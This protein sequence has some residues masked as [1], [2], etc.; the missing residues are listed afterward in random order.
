MYL[1]YLCEYITRVYEVNIVIYL[2]SLRDEMQL[3][4]VTIINEGNM[5]WVKTVINTTTLDRAFPFRD[6]ND[7]V[8]AVRMFDLLLRQENLNLSNISRLNVFCIDFIEDCLSALKD[9]RNLIGSIIVIIHI[10]I[11]NGIDLKKLIELYREVNFNRLMIYYES[12]IELYNFLHNLRKIST[13]IPTS[14]IARFDNIASD[15]DF[16]ITINNNIRDMNMGFILKKSEEIIN[17]PGKIRPQ[18]ICKKNWLLNDIISAKCTQFSIFSKPIFILVPNSGLSV[19]GLFR[20]G[21][22]LIN[23]NQNT[24]IDV[25]ELKKI[26]IDVNPVNRIKQNISLFIGIRVN[27]D[28]IISEEDLEILRLIKECGCLKKVAEIIGSSYTTVRKRLL[29]LEKGLGAKV[30]ISKRGGSDKGSTD[31]LPLGEELL[32]TFKPLIEE[33]KKLLMS[34][35]AIRLIDLRN[36]LCKYELIE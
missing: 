22:Q 5:D 1:S 27:N 16:L 32:F 31:L 18:L 19:L 7:L 11:L 30:F 33:I 10:D 29:E 34:S 26:I 2:Q 8:M 15:I 28:L 12:F 4:I 20:T 21:I 17:L 36:E 25:K 14:L 6:P 3:D 23:V 9:I 24:P 13:I 35:G